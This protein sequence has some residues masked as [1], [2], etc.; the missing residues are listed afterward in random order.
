[1][2]RVVIVILTILHQA[3]EVLLDRTAPVVLVL[4]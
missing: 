1:V 2:E 3:E 4:T